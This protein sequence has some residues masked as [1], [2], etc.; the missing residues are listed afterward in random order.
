MKVLQVHDLKKSFKLGVFRKTAPILKGVS[1][2]IEQGTV[3][4]F[5]GA[6]GA[7]K[8]TTI[9]CMLELVFPDSGKIYFFGKEGLSVEARHKIGFLPENPYFYEYLTGYEFLRFYG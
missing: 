8:T 1:F 9:K 2:E 7:G 5:L 4:G 6:N 3:T